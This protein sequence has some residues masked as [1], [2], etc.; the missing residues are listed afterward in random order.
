M[1]VLL[2]GCGSRGRYLLE[3]L[4]KIDNIELS[5]TDRNSKAKKTLS[6]ENKTFFLQM[7]KAFQINFDYILITSEIHFDEIN[8]E[9]NDAGFSTNKII[10]LKK[11]NQL[12]VEEN[13]AKGVKMP[14][15]IICG[16]IVFGWLHTGE[17]N[18]V[19]EQ[20]N[21]IGAGFRKGICPI[22]ESSDR[23]RYEYY[24]LKKYTNIFDKDSNILHFAPESSLINVFRNKRFNYI[25]AD[26]QAGRADIVADITNLPFENEKF[27][28]IICNHVM[29][30]IKNEGLAFS[31]MRRC[32]KVAGNLILTVPICWKSDTF[33]KNNIISQKEKTLHYG[34]LDHERIYGKDLP[35]RIKKYGFKVSEFKNT[36]ILS[37]QEINENGFIVDDTIFICSRIAKEND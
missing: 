21:I 22:C 16:N 18:I 34:Q 25:T 35:E 1:K 33:E 26:L 13:K 30:H 12:F 3:G 28:W 20:K 15:C 23:V 10:T 9:L 19:F 8:H 2:F 11:F 17:K 37:N 5:I 4:K 29:E 24:I 7:E 27:D 31:E 6:D 14:Q 36:A 32:L